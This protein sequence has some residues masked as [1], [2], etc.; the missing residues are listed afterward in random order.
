MAPMKTN[1]IHNGL[2]QFLFAGAAEPTLSQM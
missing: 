2:L 1:E